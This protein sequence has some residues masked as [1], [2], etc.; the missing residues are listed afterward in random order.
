[1]HL[2]FFKSVFR[3]LLFSLYVLQIW[4]NSRDVILAWDSFIASALTEPMLSE[5]PNFRHDVIDVTRQ[6]MSEI[7]SQLYGRLLVTYCGNN[8][9]ALG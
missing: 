6:S 5:A 2:N 8:V 1:M 3:K 7:F 4:Y 9:T